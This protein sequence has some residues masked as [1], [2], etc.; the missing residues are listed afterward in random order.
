MKI[1]TLYA[2]VFALG[3]SV[4][5]EV[6]TW[7]DKSGHKYEA[8]FVR[9][10]FDKITLQDKNGKEYRFAVEELSENDQ[11]YI[12]V[13][14]PP[15]LQV[16]CKINSSP[17]PIPWDNW[18]EDNATMTSISGEV[19]VQK[20]SK[21]PFSSGLKAE[22]YLIAKEVNGK[23]YIMLSKTESSFLLAEQ[24]GYK[25]TFKSEPAVTRAYEEYNGIQRRGE[26]CLGY[27]V[28]ILDARGN[29]V[30]S[31]S[32][33]GEWITAPKTVA[34]L[35]ELAVREAAS[36]IRSR[37]FDKTGHKVKVPRPKPYMPGNR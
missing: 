28:V 20:I 37:Y 14:V 6:R 2:V 34:A 19:T 5:A 22:L 11:K 24:N 8:E 17:Y 26:E 1:I 13:M 25:H 7:E 31:K 9:E 3:C 32:D 16:D 4:S 29:V 10:L 27:L 12:R 15:Q 21:R 23:E 18:Y 30:D 36:T 33:I 35:R